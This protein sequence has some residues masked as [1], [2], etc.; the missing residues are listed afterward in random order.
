MTTQPPY[1]TRSDSIEVKLKLLRQACD[2]NRRDLAM[3]LLESMKD[4]LQYEEQRTLPTATPISGA[5]DAVPVED[6]PQA[7]RN[8]AR[9]WSWC[10]LLELQETAGLARST[11]PVNIPVAFPAAQTTDL[12]RE[13]RVAR[14]DASGCLRQVVSQVYGE[15][16]EQ[17]ERHCRLV[18]AADV[19]AGTKATF[20]VF[21]GNELAELPR[22]STDLRV[23]GEGWGLDIENDH[24][25]ANLSRQMGQMERLTY[26]RD[27]GL[28]LFAGGEGHGEPPN[29]DWAH[30]YVPEGRLH[31]VRVTNWAECPNYE[32][33][34]GPLCIQVRRWGFPHS[35]GHPLYTPSRMHVD[36]TYTF[37]AGV[38]YFFKSG[39]M[40]ILA[41]GEYTI[42][43]D[44]W[45]FSGYSFNGTVWM[46]RNGALHEGDIPEEQQQDLQGVGF[47]HRNS[48]D[49]FIALRLSHEAQNYDHLVSTGK[50]FDYDGHGQVWARYPAGDKNI[51]SGAALTQENAYL[52]AP[53]DGPGP[54]Q[55]TRERLMHPL[56]VTPGG[57]LSAATENPGRLARLGE[58]ETEGGPL[59][60]A[61]WEAMRE[62]K[63]AMFYQN[64][65]NVVDMG[66]IYD[67]RLEEDVAHVT[68]TMPHKGR[69][70]HGF[71]HRPGPTPHTPLCNRL[72]QI[73]GVR[74][75]VIHFTWEPA[76]TAAR[77]TARG[78]ANMGLEEVGQG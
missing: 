62:T 32:V 12:R 14:V 5:G 42:R 20:V 35:P 57:D 60:R 73:D 46:D 63:D 36:V 11:E 13:I 54:V 2:G 58:V 77:V 48:K 56:Q 41:D 52:I 38:P 69:P 50:P 17:E 30:D 51:R 53:Y 25:V 4:T 49:A 31:K 28:T 7:W 6:L 40:D 33:V 22:Y 43:D 29:I 74:D 70:K 10:K 27:H 16:F 26:K 8:W 37:Y 21:Y 19:A 64:D 1:S 45:V 34:K 75:I 78:R 72:R 39:R 24:Y 65:A 15:R 55:D 44:E 3:S 68:L 59:K 18:F 71:L 61:I 76:W 66:Y 67:L 23:D 47:F 9:G